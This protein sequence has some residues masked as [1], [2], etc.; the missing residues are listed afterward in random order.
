MA[1]NAVVVVLE[2]VSEVVAEV[3]ADVVAEGNST[4]FVSR[5]LK[6]LTQCTIASTALQKCVGK[7]ILFKFSVSLCN[8]NRFC[9]SLTFLNFSCELIFHSQFLTFD[10]E[11]AI[12]EPFLISEC[13]SGKISPKEV[14]KKNLQYSCR[15]K[16]KR[17][18]IEAG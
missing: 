4:A 17:G 11:P 2:V 14:A 6:K 15:V 5:M 1:V 12:I 3:V 9:A 10:L 16:S 18:L 8:S 7:N 13:N